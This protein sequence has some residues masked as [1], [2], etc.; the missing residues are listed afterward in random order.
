[1]NM[2]KWKWCLA[3]VAAQGEPSVER[4]AF[5][6]QSVSVLPPATAFVPVLPHSVVPQHHSEQQLLHVDGYTQ[7]Q[8]ATFADLELQKEAQCSNAEN[9]SEIEE[10]AA[11]VDGC[12]EFDWVD[13]E[14]KLADD[15]CS[16]GSP[17]DWTP[18]SRRSRKRAK[19]RGCVFQ[20][21]SRGRLHRDICRFCRHQ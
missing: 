2:V 4:G 15:D 8:T 1:M 11:P 20:P 6:R 14:N 21:G 3:F 7:K 19:E 9:C 16:D 18:G 10:Y 13:R 5:H 17:N 12:Q